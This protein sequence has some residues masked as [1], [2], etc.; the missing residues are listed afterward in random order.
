LNQHGWTTADTRTGGSV[1]FVVDMMAP[2]GV[3]A[4]KLTTDASMTAKAQYMHDASTALADITE[5][6]YWTLQNVGS[7]P[8]ADPSYQLVTCLNGAVSGP[9]PVCNGFTT[10]VF[11]PYQGGQGAVIPGTWQEWDVDMGL[12]WS[13]RTVTCSNGVVLG[14]SGGPAIYTLSAIKVACPNAVVVQY[15][16]NIGTNNPLYNVETD[17]FDFNGT[18]Y[19]FEPFQVVRNKDECKDGGWRSVTREDGTTFRNQGDCVSYANHNPPD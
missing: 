4:L 2:E 6:G 16:V 14:S 1:S 10:L 18:I 13:T 9:M 12:F 7:P 17:L 3:G 5:L 15:G 11:E 8:V 19:D